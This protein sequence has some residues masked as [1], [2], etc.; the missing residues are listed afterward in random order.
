M[1]LIIVVGGGA[2]GMAAAAAAAKQGCRVRIYEKNDKLGKKLYITGKGRCN[3]TNAC[4]VEELLEGVV[5]NSRFLYSSF[6]GFTNEDMM[7]L[8]E[9]AGCPLKTERGGR[10]FPQSDKSSDVIKTLKK[11][12]EQSGV[13]ICLNQAVKSLWLE[14]SDPKEPECETEDFGKED[15]G[16]EAPG[17]EASGAKKR[18]RGVF[19]AG[20]SGKKI[21]ADAVIVATGGLSYPTTGS[22]GDGY[23][24]AKE[25]GHG[26]TKLL[27]ALVPFET[28]ESVKELQGLSLKNIEIRIFKGKKEYYREFGEMLFTHFGVS[29]PVLLSASSY[30]AKAMEKG[31]LQL[32]IDLKPALTEEQLDHRILRDFEE[33]KNKQFKNSLNR[34][35]PS[36]MIPVIV[37]RSGISPEKPVNEITKQERR[38]LAEIIKAFP[39]TLTGLRDFKEAII[40]QGGIS[41]KEIDPAT[42]ESKKVQDLYFAGEVLDLDAVTGGYNLQIAWSTGW[43]AGAGVG[44]YC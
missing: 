42:M 15:L 18:C 1:G 16:K 19:L 30:C 4:T 27:P 29:G 31:P 2:A 11:I 9:N 44:K 20:P 3:V 40:T 34:L 14:D 10:V 24:W 43:A 33:A 25:A 28:G 39:L 6:Y 26:V 38:R 41:V 23:Q 37:E 5:T 35:L 21:E 32:S 13:E 17:K 22:T 7:A 8:L 36:K 12:L